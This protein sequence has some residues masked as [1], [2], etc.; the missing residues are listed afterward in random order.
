MGTKGNYL[1][2]NGLFVNGA[3]DNRGRPIAGTG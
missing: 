3:G 2:R 1:K